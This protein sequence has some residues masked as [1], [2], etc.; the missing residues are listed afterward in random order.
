[1][2]LFTNYFVILDNWK[3]RILGSWAFSSLLLITCRPK[4]ENSIWWDQSREW[5]IVTSFSIYFKPGSDYFLD[6]W[7]Q[8][9]IEIQNGISTLED[10]FFKMLNKKEDNKILHCNIL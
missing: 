4:L 6:I 5:S 8:M 7:L 10:E 1:M 3:L 9:F 2:A